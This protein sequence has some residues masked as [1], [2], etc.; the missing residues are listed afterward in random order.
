MRSNVSTTSPTFST[1]PGFVV[2]IVPSYSTPIRHS[3]SSK[4]IRKISIHVGTHAHTLAS[5]ETGGPVRYY[6][7]EKNTSWQF[8]KGGRQF[9][10]APA[11]PR[12]SQRCDGS[13][14]GVSIQ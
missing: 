1:H 13:V 11:G 3:P 14:R 8:R 9:T 12:S 4:G 10:P 2:S 7:S 5:R 6:S